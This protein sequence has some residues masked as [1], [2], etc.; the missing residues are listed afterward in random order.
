[1]SKRPKAQ[2]IGDQAAREKVAKRIGRPVNAIGLV[3]P[4]A[5]GTAARWLGGT[6]V[7]IGGDFL[8]N[9]AVEVAAIG[10]FQ[11]RNA[12]K[13]GLP[14]RMLLAITEHDVHLFK[15]RPL[16]NTAGEHLTTLPYGVIRAVKPS[17]VAG[18][19]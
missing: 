3:R 7:F 10:T 14:A 13:A 16:G 12:R 17:R 6:S 9:A 8:A 4:R 18:C 19:G 1:M 2:Q 5:N 11:R 15:A